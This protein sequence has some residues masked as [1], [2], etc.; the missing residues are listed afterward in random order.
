MELST[1]E[2]KVLD[3]VLTQRNTYLTI[4]DIAIGIN[5]SIPSTQ[6]V[7]T[8]LCKGTD[9]RDALLA[10]LPAEI[11]IGHHIKTVF[12]VIPT[13]SALDIVIDEDVVEEE[14]NEE[15]LETYWLN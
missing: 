1:K 14:E 3:F 10:S 2:K 4:A 13:D 9:N 5:E 11:E 12:F 7:V 6:Q 8:H 15:E